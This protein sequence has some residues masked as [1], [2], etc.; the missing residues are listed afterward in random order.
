MKIK[1]PLLFFLLSAFVLS[2]EDDKKPEDPGTELG[3]LHISKQKPQPGDQ[4]DLIYTGVT[5]NEADSAEVEA[6]YHYFVGP[7]AYPEDIEF[8]D[9]S[10]VWKAS[11]VLP[12]SATA[13]AFNISRNGKLDNN[14]K[15]GFVLPLYNEK[16]EL[17]A[18]TK[19]SQ[20]HFYNSYGS[21]YE[22]KND[23]ALAMLEED[24]QQNPE[25]N[26]DWDGIYARL[27]HAKDKEK[28]KA[29]IQQRIK[30]R[31]AKENPEEEDLLT[32]YRFYEVLKDKE[33]SDSLQKLIVEKF[34]KSSV[35]KRK[36]FID[37][38]NAKS[39]AE[40]EKIFNEFNQKFG[41][42]EKGFEKNYMLN[43]LLSDYAEEGNWEKFD[44]YAGMMTDK[45]MQ[46]TF[47]NNTAW[48]LAEKDQ[49]L[50]K[51]AELSKRSLELLDQGEK[52]DYWTKSQ[53]E[54]SQGYTE[55]MY[56]DTYAYILMKQ[57]KIDEA[58]EY[59]EKAV[60]DGANAEY[61]QRYL[62]LLMRAGETE[63]ARD[64]A[65][66]YIK[67]NAATAATKEIFQEAY[68]KTEGSDQGFQVRLAELEKAGKEKAI[69][70]IQKEMMD[71]K[72][73]DFQLKDLEGNEVSLASLEGKTVILDFWATWC[74][75]CINS[76]P[77]MQMA[78][79]KYQDDPSVKFLF[80]DTFE[81][82]PTRE[83][84]V[85]DFISKNKYPFHVLFDETIE[86]SNSFKTA[87]DYGISGIPT[88][89]IIGPEGKLRF[90]KVGY[91]GNNEQMVQELDIM[92]ELLNGK[93]EEKQIV[94][95]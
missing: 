52:P 71:E 7:E 67:Q 59:Q 46:A 70:D 62:E 81:N 13:V 68:V 76:F 19:A 29:Y 50:D 32:I 37:L 84:D 72:A 60:A 33:S 20:G 15:K 23:S 86:D 3:A 73:P 89:V 17:L 58:L 75:P 51:A 93:A 80:I 24:L 2:C 47:Y 82:T 28:G 85:A 35:V 66:D 79:E 39:V 57:G 69:A 1:S 83:K 61:N 55:R 90:K 30:E 48:N 10:G 64:K 22:V 45:D 9:S 63:K 87:Q 26:E 53:F 77:G 11:I 36:Y 14:N 91:G 65:A 41:P 43:F 74:G 25:L 95:R 38:Q 6:Y 31:N 49:N 27:L 42:Q 88:K 18:G 40:K 4:L 5:S 78:V 92:I 8:R 12:D 54:S 34:P 21:M 16:G 44:K 94:S 56:Q